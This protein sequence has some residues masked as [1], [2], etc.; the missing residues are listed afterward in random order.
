MSQ[1]P[2]AELGETVSAIRAQLQ[3]AM[4]EG[5]DHALKFRTGP[6]ELE[7]SIEVR[8]EGEAK[9]RVFVLPWAA[10]ARG[11]I[12]TSAANRIKLTLQPI[13]ATGADARVAKETQQRP[14]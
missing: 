8:K 9:A 12:S 14:M 13:D 2:W 11:A 6:V 5:A 7:F 10:E 1:E 4:D 3:Q